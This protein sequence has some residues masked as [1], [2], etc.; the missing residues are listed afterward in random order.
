MTL[1]NTTVFISNDINILSIFCVSMVE[2]TEKLCK[3]ESLI[4]GGKKR[5]ERN[6]YTSFR[7][8]FDYPFWKLFVCYLV[9]SNRN[10]QDFSRSTILCPY[11]N[12][13]YIND[14]A[15]HKVVPLTCELCL[16]FAQKHCYTVTSY[17]R[18]PLNLY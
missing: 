18:M 11:N 1:S 16:F 10:Q 5:S 15:V 14:P 7:Y 9:E 13:Y 12:L 3:F 4:I 6:C 2:Y 8:M 17:V